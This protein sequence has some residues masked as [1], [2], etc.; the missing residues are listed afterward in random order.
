MLGRLKALYAG[1]RPASVPNRGPRVWETRALGASLEEIATSLTEELRELRPDLPALRLEL[2]PKL[3]MFDLEILRD[4]EQLVLHSGAR[5]DDRTTLN[6]LQG[7]GATPA[8]WLLNAG[9]ATSLTLSISDGD[10]PSLGGF[11][12]S[13]CD[14]TLTL[15]PD[16]YFFRRRG[17]RHLQHHVARFALPWEQREGGVLW[18]GD[19]NGQGL[20]SLSPAMA[21]HPGVKQR[22]RLALKAR[23]LAG[24]DA[25][26][27]L[28]EGR[29][30]AALAAA[31]LLA[32]RVPPISWMNRKFAL[33]VDGF[34][35]AWSNLLERFHMGCCVLKIDSEFGFRQWYYDRLEPFETHVPVKADLSDLA[36]MLDWI[37]ANDTRCREIAANGQALAQSLDF[38]EQT[39]WAGEV[40]AR[41][42][43]V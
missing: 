5:T 27:V 29:D 23:D 3:P 12:F 35:N 16:S 43:E 30:A 21:D 24:I 9:Q 8:W 32:D 42:V 28:R 39:R 37:R 4:G 33:D 40:I 10:Q 6:F 41:W 26:F 36:E 14:P 1:R 11:S 13:A 15:L 2:D 18:R 17:Y 38:E 7:R 34:S 22:L 31:G 19:I 25:R 20:F